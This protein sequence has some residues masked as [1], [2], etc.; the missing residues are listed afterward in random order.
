[1]VKI[2]KQIIAKYYG[3]KFLKHGDT[4]RGVD[5]KD[6]ES[7]LIRFKSFDH[8]FMDSK[9]FSV[10][11]YGCGKGDLYIYLKNKYKKIKYYGVDLAQEM[12][13]FAEKKFAK[14]K[15]CSF[16]T[17]Y[18]KTQPDYCV[19]SGTFTV[20]HNF[21]NKEWYEYM[22]DEIDKLYRSAGKGI[23]FN[24]MTSYVDFKAKHLFYMDP[25][26]MMDQMIRKYKHVDIV[27]SYPLYEYTVLI[28]KP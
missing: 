7:Q 21:S 13:D 11:D 9:S 28:R 18:K 5:W 6:K 1:M 24:L 16:S 25:S 8:L 14:M 2:D 3:G 26:K 17:E 20:K 10:L 4:P 22:L 27:H 23:G 15:N 12:I 19:A